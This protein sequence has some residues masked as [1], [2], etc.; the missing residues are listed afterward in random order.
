MGPA[1]ADQ[2]GRQI[3]EQLPQGEAWICLAG[4][5]GAVDRG[6][7][8]TRELMRRRAI[9]IDPEDDLRLPAETYVDDFFAKDV[10][11]TGARHREIR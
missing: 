1:D 6:E 3:L 2:R 7:R 10:E 4:D 9:A 11:V 8:E 5:E